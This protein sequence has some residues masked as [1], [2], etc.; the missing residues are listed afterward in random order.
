VTTARLSE[1]EA[2]DVLLVRAIE[3]EDSDALVLTRDDRQYATAAALSGQPMPDDPRRSET[4]AFLAA[5]ARR[6]LERLT[7][8]YPTLER[9]RTLSRWPRWLNWAVPLAALAVGFVSHRLDGERLNILAFPLLA[10]I[11][12]NLAMYVVLA[13]RALLSSATRKDRSGHPLRHA[14][15]WLVRPASARLAAQPTLER[16]V[17]LY[18]RNWADAAGPLTHARASRTLHIGAAMFAI[19]ILAGM[20]LRAR[21]TANYSAGWSGTWAG[22]ENEI[23]VLLRIIFGPASLITGIALPSVERLRELRGGGENA[24]DWLILWAV[25]ATLFVIVPRLVLAAFRGARAAM[26]ARRIAVPDDFYLRSLLRDATGRAT[27]LRVIPYGFA[28][29]DPA[30]DQLQASLRGA[31]GEKSRIAVEPE[32]PYGNEDDWLAA[33]GADLGQSDQLVVLFNLSSTPEAENHGALVAGIQAALRGAPTAVTV[34]LDDSGFR[35]RL[36]GQPSA[37]RR[38][39]ERVAA[40]RSMLAACGAAPTVVSLSETDERAAA[41]TLEQALMRSGATA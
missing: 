35:H 1:S 18:A 19:G 37:D 25:T 29:A 41:R 8:R 32:I 34:L 38:V 11:A 33:N 10:L 9:V 3:T 26:L 4:A 36:R 27:S 31:V 24:G 5:R 39:D 21:Y 20:L 28:L 12:W 30:R 2:I 13:A 15:E 40:W 7:A 22:A 23:A 17:A 16:G 6:A 14:L